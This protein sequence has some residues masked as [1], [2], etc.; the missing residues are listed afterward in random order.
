M[1]WQR[2]QF[3][4]LSLWWGSL[5][6]L[7]AVYVPVIFAKLPSKSMAG[8]LAS[9]LFSAQM[10][11]GVVCAAVY[12]GLAQHLRKTEEKTAQPSTNTGSSAT[13]LVV[14]L[15][16]TAALLALLIEFAVAPRIVARDNLALWHAV[17]TAMFVVQWAC[18]GW[19]LWRSG[20]A[21]APNAR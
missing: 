11:V 20:S 18:V 3:L 7:G 8:T 4:A 21:A 2:V 10:S 6:V 12:L 13:S 9:H 5:S 1:I 19:A 16:I 15:V 14:S 17:G